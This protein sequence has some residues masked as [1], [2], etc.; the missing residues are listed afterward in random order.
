MSDRFVYKILIIMGITLGLMIPLTLIEGVVSERSHYRDTVRQD[1]AQSWTGSQK[2]LGPILK[3]PYVVRYKKKEWDEKLKAY[4]YNTYYLHK[5]LYVLPDNLEINGS[6]QTEQRQRGI[7]S[8]PVY[9]SDLKIKGSFSNHKIMELQSKLGGK[10]EWKRARLS[11]LVSDIRGISQQPLLHWSNSQIEFRSGSDIESWDSGMHAVL[12]RLNTK[13]GKTYQFEY[14]VNLKGMETLEFSP[15]GNNTVVNITSPWPHPSFIGRYLP[16][17]RSISE[18][19]FSAQWTMSAF[20]SDMPR[21]LKS[22]EEG[23]CNEFVANSF[24]VALMNS[25]DIYHK[26]ER[27]VKYAL[28]F[29]S[30]TFIVFFL[31]EVM[32]DLRLH[33]MQYLLVGLSLTF[34]YQLIISL[35]EHMPFIAAYFIAAAANVSLIGFY[36][37]AVLK[38]RKRA[39]GFST[40]LTTL[41]SMLYA[42]LISEDNSLL[43]GSL[44][45]F[46]ILALVMIITRKL[47]WYK[48]TEQLAEQ[49][50]EKKS[51]A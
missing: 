36:I 37:S 38:G 16:N 14:E 47:D 33:P 21:L 3:V 22:C 34:F 41:Y 8:I 28:L 25:V 4:E 10:I 35:S 40:M 11:M 12:S 17:Q 7:Y 6:I 31:F 44:L 30:L 2:F 5:V 15:V 9:A 19:G 27:S 45:F 1:I 18:Q 23:N 20:S 43:M 50:V 48:V 39:L 13:V 51:A 49:S 42:I 46:A 32:K 26:T 29:I 24:G